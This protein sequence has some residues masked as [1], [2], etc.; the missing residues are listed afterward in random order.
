MITPSPTS[1]IDP[2]LARGILKDTNAEPSRK[3]GA[4]IFSVPNTSY[5]LHL[6]PLGSVSAE[7]GKRLIGI[8]RAKARRIDVVQTGGRYVEPVYGRPRRVQ[9]TVIGVKDGA[10]VVDAS[11]PIHCTP[12]DPRQNAE[13]FTPGMFVSFDVMDGASFEQI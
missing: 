12:T 7:K 13:Q 5:E 11:V 8:I 3:Q 9:G 1:K 6:V 2:M 4:I 10:V